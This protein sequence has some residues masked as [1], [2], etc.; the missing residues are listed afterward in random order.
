MKTREQWLHRVAKQLERTIF[1]GQVIPA[2]RV[3][4]GFPSKSALSMRRRRIGECW[5]AKASGDGHFE[6]IISMTIDDPA[7]VAAV[8]VHEMVH[9]IVGLAAGHRGPFAALAREVGLEGQLTAT[10]AGPELVE[11]L[12]AIIG[13]L[14]PYPHA[15][16]GATSAPKTQSTRLIKC[17]CGGCG[18]VVRTT[19]RWLDVAGA[20][21]CPACEVQMDEA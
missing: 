13:A 20:P 18:Y 5:S 3:T 14:G 8:L 12:N 1:R 19:R 4:C 16:L 10:H 6:V 21:I 11:R 7:E 17:A 2:Y 15:K 9:A